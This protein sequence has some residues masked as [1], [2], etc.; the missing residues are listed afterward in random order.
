MSTEWREVPLGVVASLD[1]E[2]VEVTEGTKFRFAGLYNEGRGLFDRGWL[3]DSDTSYPR[4]HVLRPDQLV[5]RKLTAWEG[6]I[7]VVPKRFDGYVVSPEFPTFKLDQDL[8]LPEYAALV[9]QHPSFWAQLASKATGSV[10]RRKR[11]SPKQLLSIGILLPPV[12]QQQRIIDLISSVDQYIAACER[13]SNAASDTLQAVSSAC[14][15]AGNAPMLS[16]ASVAEVQIGRQRSPKHVDGDNMVPYLRSANVK[17]GRL[18]LDDVLSMNFAPSEQQVFALR[19]GDVLVTEGSASEQQVGAAAVWQA[20]LPGMICF[21]NTLLRLRGKPSGYTAGFLYHWARW[22]YRSGLLASVA[23]GTN[24]KHIGAQR[25]ARIPVPAYPEK[26]QVRWQQDLDE[27]TKV[28]HATRQVLRS[29]IDLR[30]SLIGDLLS[31][32]HQIPEAYHALL[33]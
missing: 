2:T 33:H 26:M 3:T 10:Q 4:L 18:R 16:L 20:E 7:S 17:D 9:C 25:M 1:I 29:T 27:L 32:R 15:G 19:E 21:Q 11:V 12:P 5:M 28:E 6:P 22:A 13:Q 8:I 31:G 23:S 30:D 14:F 24:I